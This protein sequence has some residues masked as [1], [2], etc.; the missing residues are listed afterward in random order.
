[1]TINE[2]KMLCKSLQLSNYEVDTLRDAKKTLNMMF[3]RLISKDNVNHV[4]GMLT[5]LDQ[6]LDEL[7]TNGNQIIEF[8]NMED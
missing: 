8:D 6:L 4:A 3:G 7:E 1:M 5:D 2:K